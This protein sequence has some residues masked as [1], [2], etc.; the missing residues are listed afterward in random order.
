[1]LDRR[2]LFTHFKLDR[3][4]VPSYHLGALLSLALVTP[5]EGSAIHMKASQFLIMT[6][7]SLFSSVMRD[8][9]DL[10]LLERKDGYSICKG[11]TLITLYLEPLEKCEEKLATVLKV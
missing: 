1:M 3:Q 5:A 2:K 8:R 4:S 10:A 6:E 7:V 9:A 11:K